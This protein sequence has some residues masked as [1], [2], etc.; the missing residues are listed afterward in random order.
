M[1]IFVCCVLQLPSSKNPF[2][3][4]LNNNNTFI[5]RITSCQFAFS[6]FN[7]PISPGK[8]LYIYIYIYMCVCVCVCVCVCDMEDIH[9][10]I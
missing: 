5:Y 10:L 6:L 2:A 4:Q 8:S 7:H 9:G 1:C 3:V